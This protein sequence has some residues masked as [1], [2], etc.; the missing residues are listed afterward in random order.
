MIVA[1]T[2]A[3][4]ALVL[5]VVLTPLVRGLAHRL[6]IIDT[7]DARR[8]HQHPTPRGGG[9]AVAAAVV[10]TLALCCDVPSGLGLWVLAGGALLF[11][12]GAADDIFSL[13]AGTKLA[14]QMVAAV[15]AV[16]GGLRLEL[17]GASPVGGPALLEA[18][19]TV[20]WIVLITN[21]L[22]LTDGLDGLAAGIGVIGLLGAGG[23]VLRAG[24][25]E[26]AIPALALAGALAGFLVYNFNPATIFLGDSGSLLIGYALAVLPLTHA[27]AHALPPLAAFLIVAVPATDTLLAI[28]RRFLSCCLVE[29]ADGS[30]RRGIAEGLRNIVRP[31]RRHIH[32]RLLDLGFSQRRAVLLL[33]AGAATTSG[34]AY[35]VAGSPAWPVDLVALSLCMAVIAVVQTLGFDELRPARSGLFLPVLL[36][37]SRHRWLVVLTDFHLVALAYGGS[38]ALVG[39]P[40][41]RAASAAAAVGLMA[42]I[43]L[44]TF[45]ALGVYR[46]AWRSAGVGDF[47]RLA[48][49]CAA[50][51]IGGYMATRLLRLPAGGDDALVH[52][53]LLLPAVTLMR[54]SRVLLLSQGA[55]GAARRERA[56]ICGT[57]T[58]GRHALARLRRDPSAAL[59]PIGFVEIRPDLQGRQLSSLPV[60][61]TLD[62]LGAIVRD[63]QVRHLVIADSTLRGEGLHW[64]RAVCRQ[65]GVHVHRYVEQLVPYDVLLERLHAAPDL[66]TAWGILRDI[67]A[68]T[69][70]QACVLAVIGPGP[71]P[72]PEAFTW[73]RAPGPSAGVPPALAAYTRS[74]AD[75]APQ[76]NGRP[77][78]FR[79]DGDGWLEL[80]PAVA[81]PGDLIAVPL[82]CRDAL[83]AALLAIPRPDDGVM[84]PS[85]VVRLRCAARVLGRQAERWAAANGGAPRRESPRRE[86]QRSGAQER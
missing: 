52:F 51:T 63:R 80:A 35:L 16:A 37:L 23:A 84:T 32:H 77:T 5:S 85:D 4:L 3:T 49:A 70:L 46:M 1:V 48:R 58:E 57:G 75:I 67:F 60:L 79:R 8:V 9:I 62:A 26:L 34:L 2:A 59:E 50:G 29:W 33:Y 19:L 83:W 78:V 21:A 86:P 82:H 81:R 15:L 38:L 71:D 6:G 14:A 7:P 18:G 61:G 54:F 30:F 10:A 66:A 40:R 41:M 20:V 64:V 53:L 42:G 39:G 65:L 73:Q 24:N 11:A 72:G 17:L 36:R 76:L 27:G 47:G 74:L 28:A 22:N 13:R 69:A 55:R 31:D 25:A 56:L 45:A 68:A 12:V 43:Q 44:A